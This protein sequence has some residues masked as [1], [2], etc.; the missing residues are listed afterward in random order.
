MFVEAK[1]SGED[2][3]VNL[4]RSAL[5]QRETQERVVL[6]VSEESVFRKEGGST[7]HIKLFALQVLKA[8]VHQ[9]RLSPRK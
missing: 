7:V 6:R 3:Q 5:R 8:V 1:L 4:R 9:I 2:Q